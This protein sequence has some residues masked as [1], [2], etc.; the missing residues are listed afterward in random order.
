METLNEAADL[1]AKL[2]NQG[3][4]GLAI[5][6][7]IVFIILWFLERRKNE[8]LTDALIESNSHT[9]ELVTIIKGELMSTL[10]NVQAMV[11]HTAFS[12]TGKPGD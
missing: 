4:A 10:K 8:K 11:Q 12:V 9:V 3:V 5:F 7:C 1:S 6:F 2:Q